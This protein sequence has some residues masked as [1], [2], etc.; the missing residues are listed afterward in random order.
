M[1]DTRV[2]LSGHRLPA[3]RRK[4]PRWS[5]RRGYYTLTAEWVRSEDEAAMRRFDGFPALAFASGLAALLA[6]G[7]AS[8]AGVS[9]PPAAVQSVLDCRKIADSADRLACYDKA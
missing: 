6:S 4:R 2:S 7:A 8:P 3:L 1:I 9:G 5:R